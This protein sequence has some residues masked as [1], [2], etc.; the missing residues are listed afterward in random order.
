MDE[1]E[2]AMFLRGRRDP[3]TKRARPRIGESSCYSLCTLLATAV[4]VQMQL[5]R[6]LLYWDRVESAWYGTPRS[7]RPP[8]HW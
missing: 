1:C 2:S 8:S 6:T 5:L 3:F 4:L 7:S